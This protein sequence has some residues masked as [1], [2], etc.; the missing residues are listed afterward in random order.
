MLE[1][2]LKFSKEKKCNI[3]KM[4]LILSKIIRKFINYKIGPRHLC[5]HL[6]FI[7]H[8]VGGSTYP[9]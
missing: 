8:S 5:C 1:S 3:F 2:N 6:A 7:L 9:R 4:N